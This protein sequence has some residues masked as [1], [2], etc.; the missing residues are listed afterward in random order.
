MPSA[1]TAAAARFIHGRCLPPRGRTRKRGGWERSLPTGPRLRV[2]EDSVDQRGD[3]TFDRAMALEL[4]PAIEE[5]IPRLSVICHEAF[6]ALHLP[7]PL[8]RFICPLAGPAFY[9]QALASG[10]RTLKLLS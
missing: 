6:S 2:S 1:I 8:A 4:V 7:P 3:V 9:R 5:E 10:H